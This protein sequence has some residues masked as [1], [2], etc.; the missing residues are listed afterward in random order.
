[1]QMLK[2]GS[3]PSITSNVKPPGG[4]ARVAAG[5]PPP[6]SPLPA[7]TTVL[8][9]SSSSA[10]LIPLQPQLPQLQLPPMPPLTAEHIS[11]MY[12]P[13]AFNPFA[14][15]DLDTLTK[16]EISTLIRKFRS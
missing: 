15:V 13:G 5:T 1:M 14:F 8:T 11:R 6:L 4:G 9:P 16:R 12:E 7:I 10:Q 2:S 3:D